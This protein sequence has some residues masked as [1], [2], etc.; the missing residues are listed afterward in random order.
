[1][2]VL[3]E[4]ACQVCGRGEERREGWDQA[5]PSCCPYCG[6]LAYQRKLFAPTFSI[7]GSHLVNQDRRFLRERVVQNADGSETKYASLQEARVGELERSRQVLPHAHQGLARTLMARSNA[8]KLASGM[9]PGRDSAA[10][11]QAVEEPR[12]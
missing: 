12:R 8:R 7:K 3:R 1:M 10:F 6:A 11:R 4:Y 5:P 9:L 2:T